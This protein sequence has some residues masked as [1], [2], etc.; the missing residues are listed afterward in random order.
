ME[1]SSWCC[2]GAFTPCSS[3]FDVGRQPAGYRKRN[4]DI[5][6]ATKTF[7]LQCVQPARYAEA[8][9]MQNSWEWSM[10]G[11]IWGP[12][13]KES[14]CP[15]IP[16]CPVTGNW[17]AQ[18]PRVQ[19]NTTEIKINEIIHKDILLYLYICAV[20]SHHQRG[21]L[22]EKMVACRDP[23]PDIMQRVQIEGFHWYP[24]LRIQG[25]LGSWEERLQKSEWSMT[26]ELAQCI[27]QAGLV[28]VQWVGKDAKSLH[29]FAQG[30]LSTSYG[31][32]FG[33]FCGTPN[34][35]S[36]GCLWLFC[37]LSGHFPLILSCLVQP[38]DQG[39][40][41]VLLKLNLSCLAAILGRPTFYE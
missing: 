6:R 1:K 4:P 30:S 33:N 20:S 5:S 37:R 19:P 35:E 12:P 18:R 32:S 8:L 24:S 29:G 27:N 41:L 9:V 3:F 10:S 36:K 25:T 23:Q 14:S 38:E 22:L 15:Q 34:S 21:F 2:L 16:R 13:T 39:R 17:I 26:W 28:W 31:Y 40:C 7:Y 11:L